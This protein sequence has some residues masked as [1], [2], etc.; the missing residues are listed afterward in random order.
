MTEI[1]YK[2]VYQITVRRRWLSISSTIIIECS[3][4]HFKIF[5]LLY[6]NGK[7]T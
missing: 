2:S 1:Y 5:N 4:S 6:T 3:L 7:A